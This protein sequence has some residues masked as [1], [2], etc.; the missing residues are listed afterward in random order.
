[1]ENKDSP[2]IRRSQRPRRPRRERRKTR[3]Q[4]MRPKR[5]QDGGEG[6]KPL[7][8]DAP[9]FY[10]APS[11]KLVAGRL[12]D[13]KLQE[14][15]ETLI[16]RLKARGPDLRLVGSGAP[17][18]GLWAP[19]SDALAKVEVSCSAEA[20]TGVAVSAVCYALSMGYRSHCE[21]INQG[22]YPYLAF[23]FI[24]QTIIQVMIGDQSNVPKIK[25]PDYLLEILAAVV[26][27]SGVMVGTGSVGYSWNVS[28][29]TSV[30]SS[31]FTF[32]TQVM[33]GTMV[34]G[35]ATSATNGG[36]YNIISP[37]SI[38]YT[39]DLGK[40]AFSD[41]VNFINQRTILP[42]DVYNPHELR[43]FNLEGTMLARSV[44]AFS[45]T[46]R[47]IGFGVTGGFPYTL[48]ALETTI[49]N[50]KF[51][52]FA[53]PNIKLDRGFRMYHASGGDSTWLACSIMSQFD[54]R[55]VFNPNYP[56]FKPVDFYEFAD[57]FARVIAEMFKLYYKD[58][59][60]E[61]AYVNLGIT[62]ND[63]IILLRKILLLGFGLFQY[64]VQSLRFY[65]TS[66]TADEF[67]PLLVGAPGS[68]SVNSNTMTMPLYMAENINALMPRIIWNNINPRTRKTVKRNPKLYV[69]VLGIY[70]TSEFDPKRYTYNDGE[71]D[72]GIFLPDTFTYNPV[73][74]TTNVNNEFIDV[75]TSPIVAQNMETFN[76]VMDALSPYMQA[77]V[78]YS[79]DAG[80]SVLSVIG[81]TYLIRQK[82]ESGSKKKIKAPGVTVYNKQFVLRYSQQ[83]PL[84]DLDMIKKGWVCPEYKFNDTNSAVGN[85]TNST[86]RILNTE[87]WLEYNGQRFNNSMDGTYVEASTIRSHYIDNC[88]K[89]A[90]GEN[91]VIV[92]QLQTIVEAGKAGLLGSLVDAFGQGVSKSAAALVNAYVPW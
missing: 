76:K 83:V 80:A 46:N 78:N 37:S 5:R 11:T 25:F 66:G 49:K 48:A 19:N 27:K 38:A 86:M 29:S 70:T 60:F 18:G 42:E 90:E 82:A 7:S 52:V 55:E 73:D 58:T 65:G 20:A 13:P 2:K 77:R 12:K 68:S 47:V 6:M 44:S 43:D 69:P 21:S 24:Q 15:F 39:T 3:R 32:P 63:F 81:D 56:C 45:S 57:R 26:P 61:K 79:G 54:K 51:A 53:D 22:D 87:L 64:G 36:G 72:V 4:D 10:S 8:Y 31:S 40:N 67:I 50:P 1:M 34:F 92:E 59:R 23:C 28:N 88:V 62:G 75:D 16:E 41:M 91:S 33:Y 30:P 35:N 9:S 14:H 84:K 71:T 85:L 17:M 89:N 74:C